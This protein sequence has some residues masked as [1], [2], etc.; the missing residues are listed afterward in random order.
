M[1]KKY[2]KLL[3]KEFP[4]KQ[5]VVS[6]LINLNAILNLPKGTEH[7]V[8]DLHG[9]Y[10]A[11]QH[12]LKNGSGRLKEKI[13]ELFADKLTA[14][15]QVA[16]AVLIC[17]PK[18]K[19][20]IKKATF[21]SEASLKDWYQTQLEYLIIIGKEVSSKYTRSKVRKAI[22][23]D[24]R[25]IIEELLF[26]SVAQQSM[27]NYYEAIINTII[28]LNT[29]PAF[30]Y[31]MSQLIQHLTIDHLHV[32]GDIYDRG[33]LPDKIIDE[34]MAYHSVDIQWG[35]HDILWMGA[36][37]GSKV[38][39][40]NV[41]RI[42]ARYNNMPI[43]EES[44]GMSI[45]FIVDFAKKNYPKPCEKFMPIVEKEQHVSK[46]ELEVLASVQQAMAI[47]QFK[48]EGQLIQK[49][50]K[51]DMSDRNH[52]QKIDFNKMTYQWDEID[53][54][55]NVADFITVDP[56]NPNELT[57]EEIEVVEKMNDL[58]LNAEKLQKHIHFLVAKGSMYLVTN[59]NLL[60]HGCL[61]LEKSGDFQEVTLFNQRLK[62]KS[63]LDYFDDLIKA[64]QLTLQ[65]GG[66]PS[67]PALAAIWYLWTGKGSP[68]FGKDKMTTFERYFIED[69][70][71]HIEVKNAYYHL[72]EEEWACVNILEEFGITNTRSCIINGHTPVKEKKGENPIKGNGRLVVID[73]GFSKPYQK[74]TG[75]AGYTLLF[76]SH[77]MTLA[78]H[79]A[80]CGA[81]N[82][83]VDE[84]ELF[85][86]SRP[87]YQVTERLLVS[88]TDIGKG[89]KEQIAIL[90][91]L[92]SAFDKGQITEKHK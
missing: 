80:F 92:I 83:V 91:D 89:L 2:L 75:I 48:L 1:D 55:L 30:I 11:F 34:L 70:K 73:G 9:E 35:N 81:N 64:V 87:V 25:Y 67:E 74:Q 22:P 28:E 51:F 42:C 79:Q 86:A 33:P 32:V 53:F 77:G 45:R 61:P 63:L 85:S 37:F 41:I 24:Y 88:N 18:E 7:F 21:T 8:S 17:Y 14:K 47:I 50:P 69:K 39:Q 12:I 59:D 58:F 13:S 54:P 76:N 43:I 20:D 23:S 16:L 84:L 52:L 49:Y 27:S 56:D 10:E 65:N 15:E 57:T 6:E 26:T 90:K 72:R 19:I 68:L 31:E 60:Y 46:N 44:Y 3:A 36:A 38:C 4:N 29:A 66:R 62:G 78:V 5:S 82:V 71:T 40:A